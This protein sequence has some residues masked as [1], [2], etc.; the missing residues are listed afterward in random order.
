MTIGSKVRIKPL[1]TYVK[2]L[3]GVVGTICESLFIVGFG[4]V[5]RVDLCMPVDVGGSII[6]ESMRC[7]EKDLEYLEELNQ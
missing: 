2:A 1:E 4:W 6:V 7:H 5:F 3:H